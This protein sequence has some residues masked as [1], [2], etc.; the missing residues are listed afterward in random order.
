MLVQRKIWVISA[1]AALVLISCKKDEFRE[2]EFVPGNNAPYYDRI[3]TVTVQ[4]YVNRLF[5][6]LIGRE[7]LDVEMDEEVEKLQSA[8][9][10]FAARDSLITKLQTDETFREGDSSYKA[11]YYNRLY[12]LFKVKMLEGA[13]DADIEREV[14]MLSF[15]LLRDS[16]AGDW[17]NYQITE[18]KI[19]KLEDVLNIDEEYMNGEIEVKDA[20]ARMLD[21]A[22]YDRI[23]MNTFNFLRASFNDLFGRFPTQSEF[24]NGFE[25]VENDQPMIIFGE[26]AGNKAEFIQVLV[27][28]KEF[29]E[30]MIRWTYSSLLARDPSTFE[31]EK[32]MNNFYFDHDLPNLQKTILVTDEYANFE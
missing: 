30:G 12:E 4:N 26:Y 5:I 2:G 14:G 3:P 27:N 13:S 9:L 23:N 15:N 21:N 17:Y 16:L 10:S 18:S 28:S 31:V 22:V 20:F 7:P 25:I 19:Q 6:D 29:Y 11:A 32:G 1:I 24:D 8:N